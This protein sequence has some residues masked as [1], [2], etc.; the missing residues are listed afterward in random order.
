MKNVMITS[1]V[2][3]CI[4]MQVAL[5]GFFDCLLFSDSSLRREEFLTYSFAIQQNTISCKLVIFS[6]TMEAEIK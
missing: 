2:D 4:H 5:P 1:L 3:S 6:A